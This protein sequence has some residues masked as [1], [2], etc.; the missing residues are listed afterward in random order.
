MEA[1]I[2]QLM[3]GIPTSDNSI[4]QRMGKKIEQLR[5]RVRLTQGELGRA[6][7]LSRPQVSAVES[8]N[9]GLYARELVLW[10]KVLRCSINDFFV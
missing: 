1:S 5:K 10:S 9:R 3:S 2:H 8:G 7:H 6:V 4:D